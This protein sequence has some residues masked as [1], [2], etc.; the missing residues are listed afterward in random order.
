[1]RNRLSHRSFQVLTQVAGRAGRAGTPG[2]VII[3]TYLP[4]HYAIRPARDHDY[5][6]FY[7]RELAHRAEV[8]YPPL[9][10]LCQIMLSGTDEAQTRAAAEALAQQAR[11]ESERVRDRDGGPPVGILGPSP[12]PLSRLRGRYRF[13]LLLKGAEPSTHDRVVRAVATAAT[14]LP[15]GIRA[16]VDAAPG[17][18]L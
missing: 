8:G 10:K 17:S 5:E 4:D 3:Q 9:A 15:A 13:Q 16:A 7:A 18:M 2:S 14:R 12:A 11:A 1:M 6:A